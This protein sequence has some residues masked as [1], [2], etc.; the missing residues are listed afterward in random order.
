ML[1]VTLERRWTRQ[2]LLAMTT[3]RVSSMWWCCWCVGRVT[4]LWYC[5]LVADAAVGD[6]TGVEVDAAA[7][8]G[9]DNTGLSRRSDAGSVC[10]LLQCCGI[11]YSWLLMT[12]ERRWMQQLL[13]VLTTQG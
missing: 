1:L 11:V 13:V 7:A 10:G 8:A 5:G 9:I 4:V 6:D 12:L 2:L 3:Q